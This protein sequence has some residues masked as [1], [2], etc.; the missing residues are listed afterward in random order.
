VAAVPELTVSVEL[1]PAATEVGLSVQVPP[2]GHPLAARLTVPAE[3]T[4]AVLI[5][6]LA[7]AP[8]EMLSEVGLAAMVKSAGGGGAPMATSS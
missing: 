3:P 1:P 2:A 6:L 5:V 7:E 8:C 4:C